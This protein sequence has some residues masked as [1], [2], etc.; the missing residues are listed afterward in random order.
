MRR[1]RARIARSAPGVSRC[2]FDVH[3]SG[4]GGVAR[5]GRACPSMMGS[6][7]RRGAKPGALADVERDG[8]Q[9]LED[10]VLPPSSETASAP[11]RNTAC[12]RPSRSPR[13]IDP[14]FQHNAGRVDLGRDAAN[15]PSARIDD[16]EPALG[17]ATAP[18]ARRP[19]YGE[20]EVFVNR[21]LV[22][23]VGIRRDGKGFG[24]GGL[25]W[26]VFVNRRCRGGAWAG[27]GEFTGDSCP[28]NRR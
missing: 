24:A 5:F 20:R 19:R 18:R 3:A 7:H 6:R 21:D 10:R 16:A 15:L 4:R 22:V 13:V 28:L 25:G 27:N 2:R 14:G 8:G 23:V 17:R 11:R 1:H 12:R 26:K 9:T